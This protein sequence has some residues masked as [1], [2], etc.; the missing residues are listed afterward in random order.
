MQFRGRGKDK[1]KPIDDVTTQVHVWSSAAWHRCRWHQ[2]SAGVK[3]G[4]LQL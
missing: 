3:L 2:L 1:L 4:D